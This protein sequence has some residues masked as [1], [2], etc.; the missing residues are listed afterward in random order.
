MTSSEISRS[1]WI[2]VDMVFP[3]SRE[4]VERMLTEGTE[5]EPD[6]LCE[7]QRLS[8]DAFL[9]FFERQGLCLGVKCLH[10]EVGVIKVGDTPRNLPRLF[11]GVLRFQFFNNPSGHW[12]TPDT[13]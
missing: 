5:R 11:V 7:H 10:A 12:F 13:R 2:D 8:A 6:A 4:S 1:M 9:F 3:L